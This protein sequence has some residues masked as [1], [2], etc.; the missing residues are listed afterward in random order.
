[1]AR[2]LGI[3]GGGSKTVARVV[4]GEE[5]V[6]EGRGGPGNWASAS[7]V[8][9]GSLREAVQGCPEVEG[10]C[11]C[12]AGVLTEGDRKDVAAL[13]RKVTGCEKVEVRPDFHGAWESAS[14]ICDVLVIAG[15]GALVCSSVK[16]EV[17]KSGGGG[18][19]FGDEGSAMSVGRNA[20][21]PQVVSALSLPATDAFWSRVEE[22]FGSRVPAD[23]VAAVYRSETPAAQL[24]SLAE[25]VAKDAADGKEYAV[26][27]V[28]EAM[29]GLM[30]EAKAHVVRHQA[31]LL[32][33]VK[34]GLTGGLWKIHPL[35]FEWFQPFADEPA[36]KATVRII[37]VEPVEGACMIAQRMFG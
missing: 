2:F 13:V 4:E 16:G 21:Y 34:I 28:S 25:V 32:P 7:T 37:D 17:V 33:N 29:V 30:S 15:T 31:A 8:F 20:L 12:F 9:A 5:V 10:V 36:V 22:V 27:A 26:F 3:D 23:V 11:G 6:F 14:G 35:F 24:A 19:L 1:M 18:I